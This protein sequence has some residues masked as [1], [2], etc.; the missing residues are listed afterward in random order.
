MSY[1]QYSGGDDLPGW[2]K[3]VL[4]ALFFALFLAAIY[5]IY[6]GLT[7]TPSPTS[8]SSAGGSSGD[9]AGGSAGGSSG[10]SAGGSSGDSAG[11]SSGDSAGDSAGGS[12]GDSAVVQP[13]VTYFYNLQFGNSYWDP[14]N[15]NEYTC[16]NAINVNKTGDNNDYAKYC[17]FNNESDVRKWCSSDPN[18]YGYVY[19]NNMFQALNKSA[20]VNS[21]I[22]NSRYY[23]KATNNACPN[24]GVLQ[25]ALV[26]SSPNSYCFY[27]NKDSSGNDIGKVPFFNIA[28]HACD[29]NPNCLGFNSIGWL[30]HTLRPFD[31]L[32]S[33]FGNDST[34][35]FYVKQTKL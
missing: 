14:N 24:N 17:I 31:Q 23:I 19:R 18:C 9:S 27:P 33:A 15:A 26:A 5:F 30:K 1:S 28:L 22:N 35:G 3:N 32:S 11:G 6:N 34:K 8:E 12:A 10:D 29:E 21:G 4:S 16:P 25:P 7:S 13:E 2:V 20:I